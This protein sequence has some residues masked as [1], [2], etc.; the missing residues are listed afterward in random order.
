MR[1]N[2]YNSFES[3]IFHKKIANIAKVKIHLMKIHGAS[4]KQKANH[5]RI[6]KKSFVHTNDLRSHQRTQHRDICYPYKCT[7]CE[8][9]FGYEKHLAERICCVTL[10]ELGKHM[11]MHLD[12]RPIEDT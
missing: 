11:E 6:C 7:D 9:R 1:D 10:V 2:H 12:D 8:K 4:M 3:D 5:C